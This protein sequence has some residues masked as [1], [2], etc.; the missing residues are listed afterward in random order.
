MHVK[1]DKPPS[2]RMK[3]TNGNRQVHL[4]GPDIRPSPRTS[5]P[6]SNHSRSS[7]DAQAYRARTSGVQ[8]GHPAPAR[9]SGQ[10]PGHP[11]PRY[12]TSRS[13][14]LQPGHPAPS[15]DIRPVAR[16][17]GHPCLRT[18]RA[19]AHVPLRLPRLYILFLLHLSRV[20]IGLARI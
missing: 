5:G 7:P 8:P 14:A 2:S 12:R 1:T 3:R 15:P 18:V 6:W 9:K 11:A 17:S 20:S 4:P 13:F 16:T 19:K 10:K